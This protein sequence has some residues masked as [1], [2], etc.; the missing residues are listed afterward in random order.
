MIRGQILGQNYHS[1]VKI[2]IYFKLYVVVEVNRLLYHTTENT[3][4]LTT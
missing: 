1:M 2:Q 3:L 4:S